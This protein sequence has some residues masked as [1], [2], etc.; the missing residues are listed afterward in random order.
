MARRRR[1]LPTRAAMSWLDTDRAFIE[2]YQDLPKSIEELNQAATFSKW[3]YHIHHIVEQTAARNASYPESMINGY[4]NRVRIPALK[5][6]EI[7]A[8]YMRKNDDYG[9]LSPR[10][11][12][13]DKDW[14][15]RREVGLKVLKRFE[16]LK[17]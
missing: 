16:V 7:T 1:P 6:W 4:D 3:G 13:A 5:H 2:S 10:E 11:W 8:W 12:L 14:V 15:T 17:P 9:G